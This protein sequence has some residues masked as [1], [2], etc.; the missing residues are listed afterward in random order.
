MTVASSDLRICQ[1][2]FQFGRFF[3]GWKGKCAPS[4]LLH[5]F[6]FNYLLPILLLKVSL[7]RLGHVLERADY[8][9]AF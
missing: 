9:L 6:K 1:R 8:H 5:I 4:S 2:L 3:D 7:G